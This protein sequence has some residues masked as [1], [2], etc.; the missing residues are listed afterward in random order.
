MASIGEPDRTDAAHTIVYPT[1]AYHRDRTWPRGGRPAGLDL[2]RDRVHDFD[3]ATL[4]GIPDGLFAIVT[5]SCSELEDC[6][7]ET[8][9]R[10][11]VMS[12]PGLVFGP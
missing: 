12:W 3:C 2:A 1:L 8:F 7:V 4:A 9:E 11:E 10:L 5:S 6:V